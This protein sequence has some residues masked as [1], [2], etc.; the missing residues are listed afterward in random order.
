MRFGLG[1]A[2]NREKSP[3]GPNPH[4]FWWG[5]WGGSKMVIDLD[6]RLCFAYA[7][8]KMGTGVEDTRAM[9]LLAALYDSM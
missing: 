2:L 1:F 5:G 9:A 3:V 6:A 7:M 4:I 8:N